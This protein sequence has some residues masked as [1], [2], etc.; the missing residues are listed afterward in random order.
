MN[1]ALLLSCVASAI[2]YAGIV[3]GVA[4]TVNSKAITM[5]EIV[6]LSES[7]K[8]SREEAVEKLIEKKIEESELAKQNIY[9]DDFDIEKKVEQ[10]ASSNGMTLLTF[11]D[12][13]NARLIDYSAYKNEIK[14]KMARERLYQKITYQKY[15]PAEESELKLFYENNKDMFKSPKIIEAVQY[16]SKNQANLESLISSPLSDP[17]GIDKENLIV[18]SASLEPALRYLLTN[19]KDGSFTQIMSVDGKFVSFYIKDKKDF[20][21]PEF[22]SIRGEVQAAYN[23]KKEEDAVREY[24]EKLKAAAKIKIVR[25][26]N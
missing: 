19:T 1:R 11:K 15:T 4:V 21:V 26:P 18:E 24:F 16:S 7:A 20:F 14:N 9:I 23:S 10:I 17:K 5:Y 13:L 8:I 3:D 25:L 12:A 2:L 22:D 6:K